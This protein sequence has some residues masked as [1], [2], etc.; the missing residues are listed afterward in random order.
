MRIEENLTSCSLLSANS[1]EIRD[2]VKR[3]V[4]FLQRVRMQKLI[5]GSMR[6]V[7]LSGERGGPSDP[8]RMVE[9]RM[10]YVGIQENV[11]LYV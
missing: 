3:N 5:N 1:Y 9:S 4:F 10:L 6:N 11:L 7:F 2:G 8:R